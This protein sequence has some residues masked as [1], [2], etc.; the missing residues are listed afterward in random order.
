MQNTVLLLIIITDI[1]TNN[2][3]QAKY[4]RAKSAFESGSIHS[5]IITSGLPLKKDEK[6]DKQTSNKKIGKKQRCISV[7]DPSKV[8]SF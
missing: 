2:M 6:Q 3:S 5:Q 8:A 1:L 7:K 4:K